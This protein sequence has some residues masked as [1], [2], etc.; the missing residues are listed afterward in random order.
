MRYLKLFIQGGIN[1]E[2]HPIVKVC[3]RIMLYNS[4]AF[5]HLLVSA[6]N[7]NAQDRTGR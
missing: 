6:C 5:K 1:L 7:P 3:C 2:N 4:S